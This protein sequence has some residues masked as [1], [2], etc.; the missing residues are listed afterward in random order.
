[1]AEKSF[2]ET[3]LL[4]EICKITDMGCFGIQSVLSAS[5]NA[6]FEKELRRQ[7]TEYRRI[8]D[9]AGKALQEAGKRPC[10]IGAGAKM[11]SFL[12]AKI[13]TASDRCASHIAEMMMVGSSSG[14]AKV[15]RA[16]RRCPGASE[17]TEKLAEKLLK[18]EEANI[19]QMK[20]F[21]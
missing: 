8:Y 18:T 16:T 9:T 19:E 7:Q 11:G 12:S 6:E 2:T 15:M 13:N 20:T 21:L 14:V 5:G 17:K 10:K 3:Q 1:M 4:R